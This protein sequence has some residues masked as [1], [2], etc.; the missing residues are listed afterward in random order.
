MFSLR[1]NSYVLKEHAELAFDKTQ[2]NVSW[3]RAMKR[4]RVVV[5]ILL[6]L[7]IAWLP[8]FADELDTERA[9]IVRTGMTIAGAG[10]GLAAGS[11]IAI[12]FS[13]DATDTPLS[14]MLLLTIPVAAAGAA[15]GALAGRWMADTALKHHPAP[16]FSILEGAWLGLFAGAFVGGISFSLNFAIAFPILEV[17]EGYWGR[18]E[19]PQAVG[20]AIVAG[21]FW[22]GFW[23]VMAGAVALPIISLVMG[24]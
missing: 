7:G 14:N 23:G 2:A 6:T 9:E 20:M 17:P 19:Y 4:I 10:I 18:F 15:S 12:G 21:S 3:C 24:F 13:L 11:A 1:E 8:L 22:G 16:L 5:C